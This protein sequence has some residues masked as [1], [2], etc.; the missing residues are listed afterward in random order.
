VQSSAQVATAACVSKRS[1]LEDNFMALAA[2]RGFDAQICQ[3]EGVAR[4]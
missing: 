2:L 4:L 1:M 3:F